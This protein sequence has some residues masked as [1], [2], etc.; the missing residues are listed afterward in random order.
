[1][2]RAIRDAVAS[3]EPL[4]S[5]IRAGIEPSRMSKKVPPEQ[6]VNKGHSERSRRIYRPRCETALPSDPRP[7][8]ISQDSGTN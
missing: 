8:S 3:R 5:T 6:S 4:R 7:F 2:T 1:M